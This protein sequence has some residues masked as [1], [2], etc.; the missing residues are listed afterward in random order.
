MDQH[1]S[2]T[3]SKGLSAPLAFRDLT[4]GFGNGGLDQLIFGMAEVE[5]HGSIRANS[6]TECPKQHGV[7]NEGGDICLEETQS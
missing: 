7:W 2:K 4:M 3:P 6:G 1:S 5:P